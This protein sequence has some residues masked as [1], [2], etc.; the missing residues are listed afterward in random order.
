MVQ[1]FDGTQF[2][3]DTNP[4]VPVPF[5]VAGWVRGLPGESVAIVGVWQPTVSKRSWL[6]VSTYTSDWGNNNRLNLVVN[7]DGGATIST[8][9]SSG[10]TA[11]VFDDTEHFIT[12]S[13][14]GTVVSFTVD[15]VADAI[16]KTLVNGNPAS[17]YTSDQLMYWGARN[18]GT[19]GF[20]TGSLRDMSIWSG[21]LSVDNA[22]YL[23]TAGASGTAPAGT[24][25]TS[26]F[27][28]VIDT[29]RRQSAQ[30]IIR[31]AF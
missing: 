22:T 11:V 17:A 31:G 27:E 1:T 7:P 9:E 10:G 15:G 24:L 23:M 5:S 18:N 26:A 13:Y 4:Q 19:A 29:R 28:S 20:L 14:N 12:A 3:S 2:V 6:L 8:W 16:A 21:V 30:T 25:L